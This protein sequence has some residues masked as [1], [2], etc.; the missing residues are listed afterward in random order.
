MTRQEK[1]NELNRL[2]TLL[3]GEP[4]IKDREYVKCYYDPNKKR[5]IAN[6]RSNIFKLDRKIL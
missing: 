2:A 1:I 5:Q 4:E 3:T 6:G